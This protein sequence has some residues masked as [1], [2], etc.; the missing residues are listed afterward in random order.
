MSVTSDDVNYLVL[1]YLQESG[2]AHAAFAFRGEARVGVRSLKLPRVAPGALIAFLQKGLLYTEV[3]AHT[4]EDGSTKKCSV[5]FSLTLPHECIVDKDNDPSSNTGNNMT[6]DDDQNSV[7]AK[8]DDAGERASKSKSAKRERKEAKKADR[9][10][11]ARKE[12]LVVDVVAD[13]DEA[14]IAT[15]S[16]IT[17]YRA[18][19][20]V[21]P[22][23]CIAWNPRFMLLASGSQDGK[24]R[25]WRV[26]SD[27]SEGI[28]TECAVTLDHSEMEENGVTSLDWHPQGL[29]IA[30]GSVAGSVKIWT[31][32]GAHFIQIDSY[33]LGLKCEQPGELKHTLSRHTST[34]FTLKFNKKGDLLG[35]SSADSTVTIWDA[36][37]GESRQQFQCHESA[38]LDLDWKDDITFATCGTDRSVYVCKM[39]MLEPL[40]SFSGHSADVNGLAWDSGNASG[41]APSFLA[42]CSD[43]CV[44]KGVKKPYNPVLGEFFRCTWTLHDGSQSI[45]VCEQVSH[46]PPV[47]AFAYIN[48]HHHIEITGQLAPKPRFLGNSVATLMH[49]ETRVRVR[50]TRAGGTGSGGDDGDGDSPVWEEYSMTFPNVY[51]RGIL[52]GTM[53]TEVGDVA[54]VACA[55]TRLSASLEF[56]TREVFSDRLLDAVDG[57]VVRRGEDAGGETVVARICGR[58]SG[59]VLVERVRDETAGVVASCTTKRRSRSPI[60]PTAPLQQTFAYF[61]RVFINTGEAVSSSTS[62]ASKT[63]LFDAT[64]AKIAEKI[65]LPE[66]AMESFE[67][68]KLWSNVT[69]ALQERDLQKAT[70]EKFMIEENQRKAGKKRDLDGKEWKTIQ[71]QMN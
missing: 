16:D 65:V 31:K 19:G 46:H 43:D 24:V 7:P 51:A 38:V 18:S 40:R 27:S 33:Q 5:P 57:A 34:V 62:V 64:D 70:D 63:V 58:W 22:V 32:S 54:T 41:A 15:A 67:S 55:R 60:F 36:Y 29:L 52:F 21:G 39:G 10:K 25:L 23:Y 8:D 68:R 6:V 53:Y 56:R 35:T 45:Y 9:E 42:S 49:G 13:E 59:Q 2:F 71:L 30:T 26:P 3:E 20:E 50:L 4:L 17:I 61:D 66:S 37:T 44:I 28:T 47:S 12:S 69:K 48:L 11:R 14:N 1:R